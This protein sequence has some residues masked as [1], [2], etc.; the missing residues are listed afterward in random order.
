M[1]ENALMAT[2]E[3][4]RT[5][6]TTLAVDAVVN[7]ANSS[8]AGGGGVD[9]AI[10]RAAGPTLDVECRTLRQTRYRAGLA[11]G[12]AVAT[13]AGRMPAKWVIHT[14]GPIWDGSGHQ[15]GLLANCYRHSIAV[16]DEVGAYSIAFP[17]ISAG[18]YGYPIDR[19]S[20]VAVTTCRQARP[21]IVNRIILVAY[22]DRAEKALQAAMAE[23]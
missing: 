4:L 21:D 5:D 1:R 12:A 14:V 7:A 10:H 15:D 6:I 9:G 11:T 8:L 19:A 20:R 16:A 17:C 13:S 3:I 18:V 23:S 2:V 22:D